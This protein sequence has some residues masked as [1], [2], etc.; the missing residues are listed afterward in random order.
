MV[1]ENKPSV[2]IRLMN[3]TLS[4]VDPSSLAHL[5]VGTEW[6]EVQLLSDPFVIY[7]NNRYLPVI[8]AEELGTER[9]RLLFVAASSLAECLEAIR[10]ERG[11]LVG[12]NV[13]IRKKGEDKFSPYELEELA[14]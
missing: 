1:M 8:L 13:R 2:F 4:G 5:R 12:L 10:M 14:E 6:T 11:A 3:E 7:R 9:K